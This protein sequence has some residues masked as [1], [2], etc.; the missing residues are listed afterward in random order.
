MKATMFLTAIAAI[1]WACLIG[2]PRVDGT[3]ERN[4]AFIPMSCPTTLNITVE[5]IGEDNADCLAGNTTC[6]HLF[7]A[8]QNSRSDC[9][10]ITLNYTNGTYLMT[11]A[12]NTTG[13][14]GVKIM[15]VNNQTV[16]CEPGVGIR[17]HNSTDIFIESINWS[18]CSILHE[19]NVYNPSFNVTYPRV[20][21]ALCFRECTNVHIHACSFT[22]HFG[23]GV[24]LYDV[25]GTVEITDSLFNNNSLSAI[26]DCHLCFNRSVGIMIE[27]TFYSADDCCNSNTSNEYNSRSTYCI[28]NC[29]FTHNNNTL[30]AEL[31]QTPEIQNYMEH[32]SI[33]HGGGL[34][35]RLNGHS[36]FNIFTVHNCTFINNM[37][38][39]GGGIEIGIGE[40]SKSNS[41]IVNGSKFISNHALTGG[42]LRFGIFPPTDYQGFGASEPNNSFWVVNSV[43]HNNLAS[44]AGALSFFSNRQVCTEL[45]S[46]AYIDNCSFVNNAATYSGAAV[47]LDAWTNEIGG[48]SPYVTFRDCNFTSNN[49]TLNI[50]KPDVL[51][52]GTVTS[53]SITVYFKGENI[54]VGNT[55]TA[56]FLGFTTA[57]MAGDLLF[58]DNFGINGGALQLMGASWITAM[59][60]LRLNFTNNH[61]AV[62]G[63]A[64][65]SSYSAPSSPNNT[66]F[67]IISLEHSE[68]PNVT[69]IFNANSAQLSGQSIYISTPGGC[70]RGKSGLPFDNET[71]FLFTNSAGTS[72]QISTPPHFITFNNTSGNQSS[73]ASV[74][75]GKEFDI[76]PVSLDYYGQHTD[77]NAITSIL[78]STE[79]FFCHNTLSPYTLSGQDLIHLNNTST[80]TTFSVVGPPNSSVQSSTR[81]LVFADTLLSAFGYLNLN[82][83]Q[84]Q[85]GYVYN[86]TTHKCECYSSENIF[87]FPNL[88]Q[89]C[90]KYGQWIGEI[91]GITTIRPCPSGQ[92]EYYSGRCPLGNCNNTFQTFCTLPKYDPNDLCSQNRGGIL[93]SSCRPDYEHV[94]GRLECIPSSQCGSKATGT[95]IAIILV[96]WMLLTLMVLATLWLNLR[97]GSGQLYC[98]VYYFGVFPYLTANSTSSI[99]L[100]TII[101]LFSAFLELDVGILGLVH[102]CIYGTNNLAGEALR[103]LHPVYVAFLV[104]VIVVVVR[105]FPR[106]S[107]IT[108]K[109][110]SVRAICILLYISFTSLSS[111]SLSMLDGISFSGISGIYAGIQPDVSYFNTRNHL[112]YAL[113]AICVQLFFVIPFIS[114]MLFAPLLSR[115]FNMTSIKPIL[116]EFQACFKD[117]CRW[118]AG[119]YLLCRQLIFIVSLFDFGEFGS[120]FLLQVFSTVVLIVHALFQ[121]YRKRWLN[122]LDIILLGDLTIYSLFNGST[123]V[124]VLRKHESVENVFIHILVLVPVLYFFGLSVL[125]LMKWI[126]AKFTGKRWASASINS[127]KHPESSVRMPAN[128]SR[129]REPLIFDMSVTPTSDV[130]LESDRA[131]PGF[132]LFGWQMGTALRWQRQKTVHPKQET[133]VSSEMQE[134]VASVDV[135]TLKYTSTEISPPE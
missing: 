86:N 45:L 6:R 97:I 79:G 18:N 65:Y 111:T 3:C 26:D 80:R 67:C 25:G 54:F 11:E 130:S 96:F 63:G 81:L 106:F 42:G 120:I 17:F 46:H 119:Y 5:D 62:Q 40:S 51:G 10:I 64:I 134:S 48:F 60:G 9:V 52:I 50:D 74:M 116:D 68:D 35:I 44:S 39:W 29:H 24:T 66:R 132:S 33:S 1:C 131:S 76:F 8:L 70:I 102:G 13:R 105:F 77:S 37:A 122:I 34:E 59:R 118:F 90:I 112:P 32:R 28:S 93:C 113:V 129:E 133:S 100:N 75:L 85:L 57:F 107:S 73:T 4:T 7:Y 104:L 121:P 117:D 22:S 58:A 128:V 83:T 20:C 16:K 19:S 82:I 78:C 15:G 38:L 2:I 14:Y 126:R 114:L 95:V 43:F 53:E 115:K 123:A 88:D 12:V 87:C 92:C 84:C 98:M 31:V 23:S 89:V 109:N 91:Q 55:G 56:L 41:V 101:N 125:Q 103:Y 124:A 110:Y 47:G 30:Q 36:Q 49:I 72:P 71:V 94:I 69:V 21:S 108:R 127:I 135:R 99:F 27:K 61:A